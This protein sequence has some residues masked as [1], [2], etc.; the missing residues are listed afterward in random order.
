MEQ[1]IP[2][3]ALLI[4]ILGCFMAILDSSI[5]NVALPKLMAI[6]GV[7][8]DE[9]QWVMTAYL[10]TSGVVVPI[11]GYLSDRFGGKTLYIFSL[12][13]F[14]VGS[15]ICALAWSSNTLIFARVLQA[16]GGGMIIPVSMG[17][18]YLIVPR[19]KMGVALGIWGISAMMA[20]ALGPTLGGYLV[21][22][23]G[24]SWIFTINL[25]I[26]VMAVLLS[27]ALLE[28]TPRRTDLK[29]DILGTV[30]SAAACFAILLALS[31]GQDRGWTSLYIVN[32]FIFAG[33]SFVLF[34]IWELTTPE[35]LI[36][37][38][39]LRNRIFS[40]SLI[41][42]AMATVG[43][44][45]IIFL[46]PIYVQTFRGLTP[47]QA[48]L[49]IMPM[50]LVSGLM[51]PISGR[52]FDRFGA[53]PLCIVGFGVAAYYTYQLHHLTSYTSLSDLQWLLVKRAA[54]FGLA[55]MPMGTA[56]MNTIPKFLAARA[57]A[58][59][60]LVRQIAASLGI[61]FTTYLML[62][63]Q[64]YH[65]AWLKEAV[66]VGSYTTMSAVAKLQAA[67]VKL[68]MP[69]SMAAAGSKGVLAMVV[70]RE[71]FIA[72]MNDAV[73]ISA[74]ITL[75]IIP[76]GFFFSKRAVEE[77]LEKQHRLFAHL[78]PPNNSPP[79]GPPKL[80]RREM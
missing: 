6:F 55:M 44:F 11:T 22:N 75:L 28:E 48:G 60:N 23:F 58:L 21:D 68:G 27:G 57:A 62:N 76:L 54:G 31:Q 30:L 15:G 65:T 2:W 39:L 38:R 61:A 66:T 51:M 69:P 42:T 49:L 12:I 72:G 13:V 29:P 73:L 19:E 9:I 45:A 35:P 8:A 63:R 67:I 36:D 77:E 78:A 25:P 79:T 10:L 5:V 80:S 43:M 64:E 17:M 50:A 3:P 20:P 34:V 56:G 24:W 18:I 33:F 4:L 14:T 1:R 53:M 26:G 70:Q 16:I 37:I 46:M 40:L 41:A 32:L 71:G 47:M 74:L 7:S 52:L 59:N